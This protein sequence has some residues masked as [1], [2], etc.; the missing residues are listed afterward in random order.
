[1]RIA[2]WVAGTREVVGAMAVHAETLAVTP[3]ARAGIERC[4][5]AMTSHKVIAVDEVT[6]D[7]AGLFELD[8]DGWVATMTICAVVLIMT[9]KALV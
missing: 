8:F 1:M 2:R 5:G 7:S 9:S 4:L 6:S 3:E